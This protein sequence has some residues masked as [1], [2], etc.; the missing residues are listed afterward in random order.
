MRNWVKIKTIKQL[1]GLC[2]VLATILLT[3]CSTKKNTAAHRTYHN[4]TAHYNAYF[5]GNE[6]FKEGAQKLEKLEVDDYNDI[7]ALYKYGDQNMNK[8]IFPEMDNAILKASKV[9][10]RHELK[11]TSSSSKKKKK[12]KK[13]KKKKKKNKKK[14]KREE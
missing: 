1:A 12:R 14:E 11:P 7:L 6:S 10:Q 8:S 5:N 9:I 4:I 3:N 2:L 13:K